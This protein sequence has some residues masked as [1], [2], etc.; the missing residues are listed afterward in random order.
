MSTAIFDGT[1]ADGSIWDAADNWTGGSGTSGVPAAG[2]DVLV[3]AI[4][5]DILSNGSAFVAIAINSFEV[6]PACAK[7][8]RDIIKFA[9]VAA[10]VKYAGSGDLWKFSS[11]GVVG[12]AS[13]QPQRGSFVCYGTGSG[14]WAEI[15][16]GG[17]GKLYIDSSAF[18]TIVRSVI[19]VEDAA[20]G[21]AG[22]TTFVLGRGATAR[23]SRTCATFRIDGNLVTLGAATVT[24]TAEI[25]PG[26]TFN[27]QSSGTITLYEARAGGTFTAKGNLNSSFTITNHTLWQGAIIMDQSPGCVPVKT[28]AAKTVGYYVSANGIA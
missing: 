28:N 21:G 11:T 25:S 27:H 20:T 12:I 16:A 10:T 23:I 15:N 2:D 8:A 26:G 24:V 18:P 19:D 5:T 13:I 7:S 17:A 1:G 3:K 9:G 4:P 22:Y 14:T 6:S